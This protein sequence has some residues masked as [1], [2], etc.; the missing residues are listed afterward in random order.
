MQ[1]E[2]GISRWQGSLLV[3]TISLLGLHD[4]V[5]LRRSERPNESPTISGT[6]PTSVTVGEAYSFRPSATD[7]DGDR[8]SFWI[9]N[10]PRWAKFD[11]RTG[12]LGGTP[13]Q[14]GSY[15][16]V[17]IGVKD[18]HTS[19]ALPAFTIQVAST[20]DLVNKPPLI[21]GVPATT[22]AASEAYAFVPTA[23][24]P[25]GAWLS[26]EVQNRPAWAT[27]DASS[28]RLAGTP[29]EAQLG[30]YGNIIISV[31]DGTTF[32][33]LAP[34]AIEVT[35][36]PNTAPAIAGTPPP[37]VSEGETYS[38]APAATDPDGDPL[39]FSIQNKPAWATF[40][41][42][43][44]RL[45]GTPGSTSVGSYPNIIVSVSDGA[46][47]TALPS[48]AI[49]VLEAPNHAP[50][51]SGTPSTTAIAAEPYAFTP[52]AS[53]T[54]GDRLTF[55]I[56]GKPVW[57]SFDSATGKL[58]GTPSSTQVGTT[59]S[60]IVISASDGQA[61]T[62][63][64]SFSIRVDLP[65]QRSVTLSWQ[66]PTKNED[67]TTLTDLAGFEV[68]YGQ[69]AGQYTETVSLP[70]ASLTSVTIEDLAPATWYFAVKA[71][72]SS[73][74]LSSFSNEAWKTVD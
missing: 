18:W 16:D 47:S 45:S 8:L 51:L 3:L 25:E 55:S 39:V 33:S 17:V 22:V 74:V 72:N 6:P 31:T 46:A 60:G 28:G 70:S 15:P 65:A 71:V 73:G 32:S 5:A 53:D 26:F 48:F 21:S 11:S 54:D 67:G 62:S 37:S 63:L 23:S 61:T 35:E 43:T 41:S 57:A 40:A 2:R 52:T 64:P 69:V 34:F 50:V 14:V 12:E 49:E 19:V 68:H 66:A 38:F 27:F 9:R 24:D 58:A 30:I 42:S 7:P 44:G 4:A 1:N 13:T 59:Y 36:T 56:S 29:T 20:S 10:Q